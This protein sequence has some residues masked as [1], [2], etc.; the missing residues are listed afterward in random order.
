MATRSEPFASIDGAEGVGIRASS[1]D[2]EVN[3]AK[4]QTG[5]SVYSAWIAVACAVLSAEAV[6]GVPH[7]IR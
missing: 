5:A 2:S 6:G 3:I 4:L 7:E 1:A